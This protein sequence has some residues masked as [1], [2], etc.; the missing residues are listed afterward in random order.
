MNTS[1]KPCILQ[2]SLLS[3]W[4]APTFAWSSSLL[5]AIFLSPENLLDLV[6][7]YLAEWTLRERY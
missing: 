4:L 7:H 1:E 6:S 2:G 3:T 5:R